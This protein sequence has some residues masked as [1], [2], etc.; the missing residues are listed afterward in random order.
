MR[1]NGEIFQNNVEMAESRE[2]VE[3]EDLRAS[4]PQGG[5]DGSHLRTPGCE[6][7]ESDGAEVN[8][9]EKMVYKYIRVRFK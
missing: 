1:S 8:L 9:Y 3:E 5:S 4:Y 7:L 6:S 2:G